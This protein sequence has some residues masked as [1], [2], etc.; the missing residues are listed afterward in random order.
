MINASSERIV[1]H[2]AHQ[3]RLQLKSTRDIKGAWSAE[4]NNLDQWLQIDLRR[5]YGVYGVA[6]QGRDDGDWWVQKYKL[7]YGNKTSHFQTYMEEGKDKV[8]HC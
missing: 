8:G 4:K 2:R 7:Q 1:Y 3:G 5:P 6:T